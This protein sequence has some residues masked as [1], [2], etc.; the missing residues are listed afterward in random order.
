MAKY[1]EGTTGRDHTQMSTEESR[2]DTKRDEDN[3]SKKFGSKI[4]GVPVSDIKA[5]LKELR[6]TKGRKAWVNM[7]HRDFYKAMEKEFKLEEGKLK[8]AEGLSILVDQ[9]EDE[10][11]EEKK[12]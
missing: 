7:G 9:V 12:S 11:R 4:V 2:T 8:Y 5:A 6:V 3:R 10:Y 1:I